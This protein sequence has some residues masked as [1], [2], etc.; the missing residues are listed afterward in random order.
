MCG[1]L[2]VT[3]VVTERNGTIA[4]VWNEAILY[5]FA[6]L[7][8]L[9]TLHFCKVLLRWVKHTDCVMELCG[10]LV[11]WREGT[12]LAGKLGCSGCYVEKRNSTY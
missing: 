10:G 8:T 6:G 5:A 7:Q 1:G 2:C 11:E 4:W 12:T 3:S 9:Q